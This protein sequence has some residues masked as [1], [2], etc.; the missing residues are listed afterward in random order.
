LITL[1][2]GRRGEPLRLQTDFGPIREGETV[3]EKWLIA[4]SFAAFLAIFYGIIL[5]WLGL[6]CS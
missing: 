5:L 4:G 2:L 3:R 6:M 1:N